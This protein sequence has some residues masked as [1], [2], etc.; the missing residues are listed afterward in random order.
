MS[1]EAARKILGTKPG[2]GAAAIIHAFR[3]LAVKYHPDRSLQPDAAERF[4]EAVE[5]RNVLLR[6]LP[7]GLSPEVEEV[8]RRRYENAVRLRESFQKYMASGRWRAEQ[9]EKSVDDEIDPRNI[10]G[11]P[12]YDERNRREQEAQHGLAASGLPKNRS[13]LPRFRWPED[14]TSAWWAL[15]FVLWASSGLLWAIFFH[16]GSLNWDALLRFLGIWRG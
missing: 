12:E 11:T 4:R 14:G 9:S 8:F 16:R 7:G 3:L 15:W 5:A 6:N 13:G 10:F 2:A 1:P